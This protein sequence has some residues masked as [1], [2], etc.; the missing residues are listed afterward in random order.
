MGYL[1]EVQNKPE[2]DFFTE[3]LEQVLYRKILSA[4]LPTSDPTGW[5]FQQDNDRK[6]KAE[7]TKEWLDTNSP[8]WMSDWLHN[9]QT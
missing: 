6:Q 2:P 4:R 1:Q 3:N 9:R 8:E 5:I 7:K